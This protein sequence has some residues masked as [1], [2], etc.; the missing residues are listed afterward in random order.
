M[1]ARTAGRRGWIGDA[2]TLDR[3]FG[4]E[5]VQLIYWCGLAVVALVAFGVVGAAVGMLIR[6][7]FPEGLMVGLPLLV[8]GLAIALVLGLVWRGACEFF[9]AV[10]QIADDLRALR[11]ANESRT[12]PPPRG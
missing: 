2:L 3:D 10:F 9:V 8:A 12:G 6:S 1:Q 4:L 11:I 5:A 7:G